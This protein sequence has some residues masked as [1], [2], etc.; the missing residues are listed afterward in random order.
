MDIE[1]LASIKLG[2]KVINKETGLVGILKSVDRVSSSGLKATYRIENK[3]GVRDCNTLE[4]ITD[5]EIYDQPYRI[6]AA[7]QTLREVFAEDLDFRQTYIAN[8]ACW[9][10]DHDLTSNYD[11]DDSIS[12]SLANS[13]ADKILTKLFE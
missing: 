7:R 13:L 12:H 6:A 3:E 11:K 9:I 2:Q 10:R 8:I 1:Q 4:M 5:Y